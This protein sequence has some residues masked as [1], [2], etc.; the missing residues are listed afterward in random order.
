MGGS[1]VLSNFFK[2]S[3][4]DAG[5]MGSIEP[6]RG[7]TTPHCSLCTILTKSA[8]LREPVLCRMRRM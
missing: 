3:L 7:R 8:C 2:G 6:V 1:P 5:M 4:P